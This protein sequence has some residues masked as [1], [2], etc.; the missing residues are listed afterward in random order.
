[1]AD[2]KESSSEK[3]MKKQ[4]AYQEHEVNLGRRAAVIGK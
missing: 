1:L 3:E 2:N 4:L